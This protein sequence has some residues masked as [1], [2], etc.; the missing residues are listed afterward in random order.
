[1]IRALI[2]DFFDV[3]APDFYRVWLEN[4][5]YT[6]TDK[7]LKV[8]K[9]IDKGEIDLEEYYKRLSALSGQS[10]SDIREEFEMKTH[11]NKDILLLIDQLHKHYRIGLVTNSPQGLVRIILQNNNIEK[12]FDEIIIS[13][14][15]GI[16]KP[17]PRI[18]ELALEK[19]KAT[20]SETVVVDD[21]ESYVSSARNQGIIGIQFTTVIKLKEELEKLKLRF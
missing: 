15:V 1:M 9:A 16:V 13:G 5:G 12:Y 2:F 21:L 11:V 17:N 10:P 19:L 7:F 3:I 6:R 20:P 8:A 18:Y 4:N 14:E